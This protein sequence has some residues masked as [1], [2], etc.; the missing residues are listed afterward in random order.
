MTTVKAN[1]REKKNLRTDPKI[2]HYTQKNSEWR[3]AIAYRG[4]DLGPGDAHEN[5]GRQNPQPP[6]Q[7]SF[8]MQRQTHDLLSP[9]AKRRS[10]S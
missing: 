5:Y 2:G 4:A 10:G 7:S 8:L 9:G 6:K 3:Q 1:E